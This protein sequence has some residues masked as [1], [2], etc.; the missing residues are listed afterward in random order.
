VFALLWFGAGFAPAAAIGAFTMMLHA[1]TAQAVVTGLVALGAIEILRRVKYGMWGLVIF[2]GLTAVVS[3]QNYFYQWGDAKDTRAAY[4][5]NF[6]GVT[7]YLRKTPY[8]G[9]LTLSSPFPNLPHDPFVVDM[10]LFRDDLDLRWFDAREALVFPQTG[11]SLLV[12]PNNTPPDP[13]F[14]SYLPMRE[15]QRQVIRADDVDPY[16]DTVLWNPQATLASM[17]SDKSVIKV[18]TPADFA[19]AVEL[20]A[21]SVSASTVKGGDTVKVITFWRIIDPARLGERAIINYSVEAKLFLHLV[22][23]NGTW[24]AGD[25]RLHAPTWNWRRGDTF[26]Q[27]HRA[28]IPAGIQGELNMLTG[29]YSLPDLTRLQLAKGGADSVPIATIKV[30]P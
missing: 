18:N 14:A 7:D 4:F 26:A 30:T 9:S 5:A 16:F 20:V 2:I 17:L 1:I 11:T 29:I 12:L 28:L 8:R 19:G 24:A 6:R 22:D 25:D 21:Y 27:I 23:A 10:R 13:F 3:F 15:A